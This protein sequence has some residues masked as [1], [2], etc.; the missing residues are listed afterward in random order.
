M[1][2]FIEKNCEKKNKSKKSIQILPTCVDLVLAEFFIGTQSQ[3]M[4]SKTN[5]K[6][7]RT[8]QLSECHRFR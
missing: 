1:K 4:S 8:Q 6:H 2:T 3:N 7:P 5:F